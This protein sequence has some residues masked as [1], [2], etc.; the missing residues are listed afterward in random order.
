MNR[1]SFFHRL[2]GVSIASVI[3]GRVATPASAL[4]AT[5]QRPRLMDT[6]HQRLVVGREVWEIDS[7]SCA[8]LRDGKGL[9]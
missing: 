1:R 9:R 6:L 4:P 8:P 5:I 3:G 2:G 7:E